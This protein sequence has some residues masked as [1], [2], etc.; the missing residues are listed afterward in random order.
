MP[1]A[2]ETQPRVV[3]QNATIANG[4]TV[5]DAIALGG[6]TLCGL[7]MPASVTSTA[8]TFQ[9]SRDGTNFAAIKKIDGND[10]SIVVGS[11]RY[12]P[13]DPVNFYGLT[14]VKLVGG[15]AESGAKTIG[16]VSRP[17]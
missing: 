6:T 1:S 17:F 7:V 3:S 8:M 12:I 16:V 13:L 2:S 14:H 4:E 9:G 11:S 15:S 5:S 10:L